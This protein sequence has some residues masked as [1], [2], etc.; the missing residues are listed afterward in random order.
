MTENSKLKQLLEEAWAKRGE[1]KY[2]DARNLVK[3]AHRLCKENDYNSLGRIFHVYMQFE[4]DHDNYSKAI[5]LSQKSL[6]Y[7]K[8]ANNLDNIAH[9][10]RH[11]A[12]LQYQLGKDAE[13]EQNYREAIGIYRDNPNTHIGNLA[14]ALRGFGLLLEKREKIEEAIDIWK[15]TK[16]LY[17]SINLQ[18]GVDEANK[19]LNALL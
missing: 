15:E 12:D 13:S 5:E 2:D 9:S 8:K 19:K 6:S 16:E 18:E 3:E 14:N 7:Y 10:T 4:S 1:E 17:A 11:I